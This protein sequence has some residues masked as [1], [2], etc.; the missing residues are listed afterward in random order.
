MIEMEAQVVQKDFDKSKK[1]LDMDNFAQEVC[2]ILIEANSSTPEIHKKKSLIL[3]RDCFSIYLSD[4]FPEK[5]VK[6]TKADFSIKVGECFRNKLRDADVATFPTIKKLMEMYQNIV[7]TRYPQIDKNVEWD[8]LC[9]KFQKKITEIATKY[10]KLINLETIRNTFDKGEDTSLADHQSKVM[11]WFSSPDAYPVLKCKNTWPIIKQIRNFILDCWGIRRD[12]S[13]D[14][15]KRS[16][17]ASDTHQLALDI[18]AVIPPT[19]KHK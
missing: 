19:L 17:F 13:F 2:K 15:S 12:K 16:M 6:K 14:L 1:E 9:K 7:S 8:S 18:A 11:K 3:F 4:K 10:P 5:D